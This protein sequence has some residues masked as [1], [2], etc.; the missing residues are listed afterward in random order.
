M[1]RFTN[2]DRNYSY[3]KFFTKSIPILFPE[4]KWQLHL[5]LESRGLAL[6]C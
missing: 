2:S 6:V 1:K 5:I 3:A 4:K